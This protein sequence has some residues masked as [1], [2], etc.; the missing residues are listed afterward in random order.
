VLDQL[1]TQ[2][3]DQVEISSTAST[4]DDLDGVVE[5][6]KVARR[7]GFH[8]FGE[9][10]KK[11]HLGDETRKSEQELNEDQTIR[12][13]SALLNAGAEK[14]YWE[15]HLLRR[16]IG[17]TP[18]EILARQNMGTTQVVRVAEAVGPARIVF[19]VSGLV[20]VSSRRNL[21]FWLVRTFGPDV[22]IGNARLEELGNLEALRA[23]SHPVFGFGEAGDYP[24]L[25][26]T[27]KHGKANSKW[28][29]DDAL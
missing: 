8:V 22:N 24:W 25:R 5:V 13:F 3:F 10:G 7:H 20:P 29:L 28:W 18:D 15:G 2:G 17:E 1:G 6:T 4:R 9:V 26:S 14:V 21:Q 11:F 23:G 19:E 16:V 27:L 12:E